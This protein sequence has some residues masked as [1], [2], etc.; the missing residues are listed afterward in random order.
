MNPG[1]FSVLEREQIDNADH[2]KISPFR[3]DGVS[4]CTPTRIWEVVLNT[5]A[6]PI[7]M[8]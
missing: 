4:Y 7:S 3:V 1:Q 8:P 5:I 2:F 6:V